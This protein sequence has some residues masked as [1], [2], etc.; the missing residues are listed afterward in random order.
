MLVR[1]AEYAE[2]EVWRCRGCVKGRTVEEWDE[3]RD[4]FEVQSI[5]ARHL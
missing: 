2:T 1:Q 4:V 3:M 5:A